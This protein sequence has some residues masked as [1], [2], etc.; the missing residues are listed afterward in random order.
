M[1]FDTKSTPPIRDLAAYICSDEG[2]Q[3]ASDIF[4]V[5]NIA[6]DNLHGGGLSG[7][8]RLS[9]EVLGGGV[10]LAEMGD[11]PLSMACE[12][13]AELDRH[14]LRVIVLGHATDLASYRAL[15]HAGAAEYFTMPADAEEVALACI[16]PSLDP[17]GQPV[18]AVAAPAT[19]GPVVGIVGTAG[20]VGASLLAQNLA[21]YASGKKGPGLHTALLDADLEFGTQAI[22]FGREETSGL[23]DALAATDRVDQTFLNATMDHVEERLS[24]YSGQVTQVQA[25]KEFEAGLP[26]LSTCLGA[27]FESVIAD[28]PRATLM[29]QPGL[30]KAM[31]AIVLLVPAGFAGVYTARRLMAQITTEAPQTRIVPVLADLRRDARL[32][33]KDIERTLKTRM[34]VTLP[35]CGAVLAKAHRAARPLIEQQPRGA[36]AKS[37]RKV[38]SAA[39]DTQT[40]AKSRWALFK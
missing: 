33:A 26:A 30:A 39:T 24:L 28:I 14:D 40:K 3:V 31:S 10:I 15:R 34:A 2:A 5:A 8:A 20:G 6:A 12:C 25:S 13:V 1:P 9:P 35:E 32:S 37:V 11:I 38:W 17:R 22:D 16:A 21:A 27:A 18:A 4:A 36:W 7:A 19:Q 23:L 29:R